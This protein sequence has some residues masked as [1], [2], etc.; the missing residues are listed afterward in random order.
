MYS[1]A[2]A[3]PPLLSQSYA[4]ASS[5]R[6]RTHT[7]ISSAHTV[8][9]SRRALLRLVATTAAATA[10]QSL[11]A[12]SVAA[13]TDAAERSAP[14]YRALPCPPGQP[15]CRP[16]EVVDLRPGTGRP[17]TPGSTVT[18]R[19]TGRLADRYGWPIQKEDA[20]EVSLVVGRG[21]LIEGFEMGLDGM[22]EG[23]KRRIIIPAELGY[24]D[25]RKGPLPQRYGDR[26]RLFA[27]VLNERRYKKAGDLVIDVLLRRVRM[28]VT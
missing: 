17:V 7:L 10:L 5:S 4:P 13:E 12:P 27:T 22:R 20:D 23:G 26:R 25:E 15:T 19:W 14:A 2:F 3:P 21:E 6:A 1:L 28:P 11:T 16:V 24:K 18:L 9:S 8:A